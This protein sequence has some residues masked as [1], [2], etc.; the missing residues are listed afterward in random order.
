MKKKGFT[1]IELLAVIAILAILLIV[2]IPNVIKL[3]N[4]AKKSAFVTEAQ[5]IVNTAQ[6]Q[7]ISDQIGGA[8]TACYY[9]GEGT[10]TSVGCKELELSGNSDINYYVEFSQGKIIRAAVSNGKNSIY[11]ERSSGIDVANITKDLVENRNDA[12]SDYI[13]ITPSIKQTSDA[14]S[15]AIDYGEKTKETIERGEDITIGT[16]RF[17]VA[18]NNNG[19]I[20]AIP[21]YN[22]Y[23]ADALTQGSLEDITIVQATAENAGTSGGTAG[24][25]AFST[26][27][28]WELGEQAIDMTDERNLIQPYIEA[29]Q[30]TLEGLGATGIT[31]RIGRFSDQNAIGDFYDS[32]AN[33]LRNP[34][35]V[36][37]YWLGSGDAW[38]ASIIP[39]V[40]ESGELAWYGYYS[41]IGVRPVLIIN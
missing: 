38:N 30:S 8:S 15:N 19:T 29:Y 39:V 10:A 35:G 20:M 3:F 21:Y 27:D 32:F 5:S 23:I 33:T 25:T 1:L 11:L 13:D 36:G 18:T 26:E 37:T 28:Y 12:G 9:S 7:Y 16:E 40:Y 2:A 4:N 34:S 22:L 24:A 41:S 17:K 31:V 6:K 14:V